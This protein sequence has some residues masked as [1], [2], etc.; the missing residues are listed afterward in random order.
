MNYGIIQNLY[1]RIFTHQLSLPIRYFDD[2][3]LHLYLNAVFLFFHLARIYY[4]NSACSN[5]V[6]LDTPE[7]LLLLAA[8]LELKRICKQYSRVLSRYF[9]NFIQVKYFAGEFNILF[10]HSQ[11]K[12]SK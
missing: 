3:R 4:K 8:Y 11:S 9:N 7:Y 6:I 5:T 1:H 12:S 2:F 10:I